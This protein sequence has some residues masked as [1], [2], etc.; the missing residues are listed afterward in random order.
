MQLIVRTQAGLPAFKLE[1]DGGDTFQK[2]TAMAAKKGN[3][4][5]KTWDGKVMKLVPAK[6]GLARLSWGINFL[7]PADTPDSLGFTGGEVLKLRIANS[8]I[9]RTQA[10]LPVHS[11]A[12]EGFRFFISVTTRT[13]ME[14]FK[15]K[16]GPNDKFGSILDRAIQRFGVT[17][18]LRGRPLE[19]SAP[20]S[21]KLKF[22]GK[23]LKL[24]ERILDADIKVGDQIE[25][26]GIDG[27][28]VPKPPPAALS[29]PGSG[30][31]NA[32]ARTTSGSLPGSPEGSPRQWLPTGPNGYF[33]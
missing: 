14:L 19:I 30:S 6:V 25:L 21:C 31:H 10:P 17:Q 13:G 32:L 27:I 9:V 5:K 23:T 26:H 1:V 15:L 8:P 18:S 20:A 33:K 2:V 7:N 22:M 24:S 12:A 29:R 11:F 28:K 3:V 16:V 4:V